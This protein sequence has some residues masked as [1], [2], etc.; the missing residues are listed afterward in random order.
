M[1]NNIIY[2]MNEVNS[3]RERL[4]RVTFT[5]P[6]DIANQLDDDIT[7]GNKSRFAAEA[8]REKI[9]Y[10]KR[11]RALKRLAELPPTFTHI[12]DGAKY[13]HEMREAEGKDRSERLGI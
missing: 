4:I 11:I 7:K 10:E 12:E 9:A 6:Q 2:R 1:R 13:I 8:M 5:I 3:S